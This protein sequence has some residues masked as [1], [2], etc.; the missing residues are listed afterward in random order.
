MPKSQP[1]QAGYRGK[2]KNVSL[3]DPR[4]KADG[5]FGGLN[6]AF[7]AGE[8]SASADADC[9]A[10]P[11]T[12]SRGMSTPVVA[13]ASAED[14]SYPPPVAK[15]FPSLFEHHFSVLDTAVET[16]VFYRTQ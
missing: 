11:A 1:T 8:E 9:C 7:F 5:A 6:L 3:L 4:R 12:E 16:S 13:E 10:T 14:D 15:I 2:V